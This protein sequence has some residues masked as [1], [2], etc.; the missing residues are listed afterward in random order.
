MWAKWTKLCEANVKHYDEHPVR[1]MAMA[2]GY[3]VVASVG[4]VLAAKK[5]AK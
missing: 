3:T 1:H 5:A 4:V 2:V